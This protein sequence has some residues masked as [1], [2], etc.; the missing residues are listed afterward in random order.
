MGLTEY[1]SKAYLSLTSLTSAT[2]LEVNETSGVPLSRLYDV[3]KSLHKKGFIEITRGKPLKYSVIPPQDVFKKA[4]V[5]IKEEL[6]EAEAEVKNIYESQISKSP[7]PIWLI[8]G[9]DKI[10]K[11]ELEIIGRAKDTLHI[12][13]GFMFQGELEKLDDALG[14][15]LKKGVQT[16]II[17]APYNITDGEKIDISKGLNKLDCQ[18]KTFQIPFIKALIRDKKEMML[19]FSKFED[20]SVISQ[21]AIGV[22]N[23]YTEF[24]ETIADLYNLV[25][26]MNLF[27]SYP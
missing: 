21:T 4:R 16:R 27:T 2:A 9:T 8:Y 18:M 19:I 3:L 7:A 11:K 25:W 5:K 22:W 23:K 20:E 17:A 12:A 6:D 24:V 15:S 26:N 14:K 10:V 13:A 1:E